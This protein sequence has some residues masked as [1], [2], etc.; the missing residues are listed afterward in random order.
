MKYSNKQIKFK[1]QDKTDGM[2]IAIPDKNKDDLSIPYHEA[3]KVS[4]EDDAYIF[5]VIEVNYDDKEIL[6][7]YM[8]EWMR[9][10]LNDDLFKE[11]DITL[12]ERF[13]FI[14]MS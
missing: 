2:Y 4:N 9:L 10:N 5:T 11:V 12:D 3:M 7:N 14:Y 8:S 6:E 13:R 1:L